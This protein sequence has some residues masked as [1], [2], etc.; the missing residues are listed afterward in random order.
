MPIDLPPQPAYHVE[1][2]VPAPSAAAS[3]MTAVAGASRALSER[4]RVGT[5]PSPA[6]RMLPAIDPASAALTRADRVALVDAMRSNWRGSLASGVGRPDSYVGDR[7]A[8]AVQFAGARDA[9]SRGALDSERAHAV[10]CRMVGIALDRRAGAYLKGGEEAARAARASVT[11][12]TVAGCRDVVAAGRAQGPVPRR[13]AA[14]R[15]DPVRVSS[16]AAP[17]RIDLPRCAP[18]RIDLPASHLT[19]IDPQPSRRVRI[20]PVAFQVASRDR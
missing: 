17:V 5:D 2:A 6:E 19:R 10:H 7:I 8:V 1:R 16:T 3:A 11:P 12:E 20:D 13:V 15:V 4:L 9:L 18:A 14:V